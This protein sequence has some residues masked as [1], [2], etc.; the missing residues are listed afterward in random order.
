MGGG[1]CGLAGSD[2]GECGCFCHSSVSCVRGL[3]EGHLEYS[4]IAHVKQ[5]DSFQLR[6][7]GFRGNEDG[8]IGIRIYPKRQENLIRSSRF[9]GVALRR[10][11]AGDGWVGE[12]AEW[13]V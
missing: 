8:N 5:S 12:C 13:E 4:R 6:V 1:Y 7:F 11:G 10:A 9:H 2:V 3:S